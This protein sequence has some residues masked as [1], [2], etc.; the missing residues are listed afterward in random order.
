MAQSKIRNENILPGVFSLA[1]DQPDD[2][3]EFV[4]VSQAICCTSCTYT[5][6]HLITSTGAWCSLPQPE[7]LEE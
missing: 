4:L 3:G 7:I 1:I 6:S 5:L 2:F